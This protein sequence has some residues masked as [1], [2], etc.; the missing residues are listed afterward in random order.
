[1]NKNK[2]VLTVG[3]YDIK[4]FE[5]KS[6][7]VKMLEM[8]TKSKEV[9]GADL[10]IFPECANTGYNFSSIQEVEKYAEC[11]DGYTVSTIRKHAN[12][13]NI[14]VI[15]GFIEKKNACYYNSAVYIESSGEIQVYRKTHLPFLGVDR[16]VSDGDRLGL[17]DT[18]FGKI[19]VMICY[20]LRFPEVAREL[21]LNGA[22]MLVIPTNLPKGG[23]AH[24]NVFT[25]ARA[26]E[27]RVYVITA[28]RIGNERGF[29]YIGRSQIVNPSGDI[30]SE[31]G[32]CE[33]LIATE[34]DL[35]LAENKD[36]IVIPG[37]YETHLFDDRRPELYKLIGKNNDV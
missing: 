34:I 15:F 20:D 9:F 16:F 4:I 24:P 3:Q 26:C 27:N 35:S 7:I 19:G 14:N 12:E 22:R 18:K 36:M 33:G 1:M 6:N 28:N 8:I 5:V 37:E 13:L 32:C 10:V 11:I 21:S 23:E 31:M 29:Q 30:L 2:L 17:F 25:K